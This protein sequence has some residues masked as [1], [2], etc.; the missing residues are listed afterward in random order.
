MAIAA[1]DG[2]FPEYLTFDDVLLKPG[3]SEVLPA[4]ADTRTRLTRGHRTQH[5]GRV[6][7][8]GYG[9]RGAPRD[10]HGSG[11]RSRRRAPE[12]GPSQSRQSRF[13]G[14]RSSNPAWSSI[15]SRSCRTPRWPMP[16]NSWTG[17]RSRAFPSPSKSPMAARAGKLVRHPDQPRCA[18]CGQSRAT[19]LRAYDQGQ[20]GHGAR[21]RRHARGQAPVALQPDRKAPGRG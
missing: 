11:R 10:R 7:R 2:S 13:A 19:G 18:F 21:R 17:T 1:R 14:S 6:L 12:H 8:H 5:T 4:E 9:N 16:W 20:L 3:A 15:R